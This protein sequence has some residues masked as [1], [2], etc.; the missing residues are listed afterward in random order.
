[1]NDSPTPAAGQNLLRGQTSPYLL[2]HADNP[3]HWMPWGDEAFRIAL[4]T[5]LPIFLSIGYASCHWCHVMAHES[6]EDAATAELLNRHFVCIKVDRE[7]RPD[8]DA[9]YMQAVQMMTGSGGWP[10]SVFLTAEGKPFYGGTYYPP[11][12]RYGMPSFRQVLT[13]VARAWSENPLEVTQQA[14][15]LSQAVAADL[16]SASAA[17]ASPLDASVLD[18]AVEQLKSRYDT[19]WGGFS[20]APKFPPEGAV[21]LLLRQAVRTG[22]DAAREMAGPTLDAMAHGGIC[23]QA[24]GGFHRY[25][26]DAQWL[27]PH[28]E[29]MLYDNAL[30][31]QLYTEAWQATQKPLYER[32]ARDTLDYLLRDMSDPA[33]GFHSAEDADS[34]GEEGLY[35]VWTPSEIAE[36]VGS[37]EA[38]TAIAWFGATEP[39]N[40]EGRNILHIPVP[41]DEFA[42]QH[43]L[44]P[45]ALSEKIEVWRLLLRKAR[46]KRVRPARDDKV[47]AAWNG[48][49]ISALSRAAQAFGE[50]QYRDAAERAADFIRSHMLRDGVLLRS[51]RAG[52]AGGPGFLDDYAHMI[53]ALTDLYEA[54]FDRQRLTDAE[55]LAQVLIE[56]FSDPDGNGF[57]Y[58]SRE[59]EQLIARSKPGFDGA[60][61]SGN[62]AAALALLRLG[63][64]LG[65]EDMLKRGEGAFA[66]FARD[67]AAAPLAFLDMLAALDFH[68]HP[69][70][71]IV[72]A[73][74]A[75]SAAVRDMAREAGRRFLPHKLLAHLPPDGGNAAD[76][77]PDASLTEGRHAPDGGGARAWVCRNFACTAPVDSP[78]ALA[79]AL[80]MAP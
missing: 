12:P 27:T 56:R 67:I 20:P 1:V 79:K 6:F 8:V 62:S 63:R 69:G 40:F 72:I 31:A 64:L 45:E 57:F 59:H 38:K 11:E 51:W 61:P 24:G 16:A 14:E 25:S 49:A 19:R 35:Y 78:D 58:A 70:P 68:L 9:I 34:E 65:R 13:G 32:V 5:R 26:T 30:L 47:L 23:D 55:R 43:G 22:D 41:L 66:A 74:P 46:E 2:Q 76:L 28:F 4:E 42:A 48:M 37:P 80:D 21:S 33:G 77:R 52:R 15:S 75:D 39:G 3:V 71:E 44:R 50:T 29:K 17:S 60:T 18:L 53:L 36:A 10:L 54:T 7:E 73:G